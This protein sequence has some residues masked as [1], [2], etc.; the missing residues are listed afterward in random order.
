MQTRG[1]QRWYAVADVKPIAA[2]VAARKAQIEADKLVQAKHKLDQAKAAL[3]VA[4]ADD[5]DSPAAIRAFVQSLGVGKE[6]SG[7]TAM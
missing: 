4:D 5:I 6:N 1:A 2:V 7:V 3:G